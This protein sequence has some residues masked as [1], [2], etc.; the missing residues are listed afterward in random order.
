MKTEEALAIAAQA[1]PIR[2]QPLDKL[3]DS[4]ADIAAGVTALAKR[5]DVM[6]GT[7]VEMQKRIDQAAADVEFIQNFHPGQPLRRMHS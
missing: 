5:F 3:H 2:R 1:K 6:G 7:I 4:A